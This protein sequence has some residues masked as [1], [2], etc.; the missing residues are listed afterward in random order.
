MYRAIIAGLVLLSSITV[1]SAYGPGPWAP[2]GPF[3]GM[4]SQGSSFNISTRRGQDQQ[5]YYAEITLSGVKPEQLKIIP[6]GNSLLIRVQQVSRMQ[7]NTP[8]GQAGFMQGQRS[9]SQRLS[10]PPD[11]NLSSMKMQSVENRLM[12]MVPRHR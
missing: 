3:P 12:I 7:R 9:M 2:P 4:V 11:A 6:Q 8:Q 1:A 10:F 5:A